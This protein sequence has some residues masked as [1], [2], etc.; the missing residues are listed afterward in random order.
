MRKILVQKISD[1]FQPKKMQDIDAY[2]V[3][4]ALQDPIIRK[5]W[6][7]G[8]LEEIVRLNQTIDNKLT[9]GQTFN[10]EDLSHRRRALRFVLDSALEAQR[11]VRRMRSHNPDQMVDFD[12]ESVAVRTSR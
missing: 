12:L 2:E 4:D 8:I 10:I 3:L 11:E 7:Y 1:L 5:T 6:L 9:M